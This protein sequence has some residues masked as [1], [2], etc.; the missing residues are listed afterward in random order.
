MTEKI[1]VEVNVTVN[2]T[3]PQPEPLKLYT[4]MDSK[5]TDAWLDKLRADLRESLADAED[6]MS[7]ETDEDEETT[8]EP[9]MTLEEARGYLARAVLTKGP[10][11]IYLPHDSRTYGAATSAQGYQSCSY[12]CRTDLPETDP[13][14]GTP[15]LVGVALR[16]AG[17]KFDVS[18]EGRAPQEFDMREVWNLSE[19]AGEYFRCAQLEQDDSRP[20]G[21]AYKCA[22]RWA[23][24]M[25]K[26]RNAGK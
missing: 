2:E 19:D 9:P 7:E 10:E 8:P 17:R 23:E 5:I 22:E 20:W 25:M 14:H 15:C 3:Q 24:E 12:F 13:R 21:H 1:T 4:Q 16:M 26:A 6:E 11:F 18:H